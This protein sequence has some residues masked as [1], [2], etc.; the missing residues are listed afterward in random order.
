MIPPARQG[1]KQLLFVTYG[2]GHAH[3]I[4]PVAQALRQSEACARGELVVH[5]LGLPAATYTLKANGIECLGFGDFLDPVQDADAL[6]WGRELAAQH[7]SP[8]IG[9]TYEDSVAYLGLN[10]K[11]LVTRHGEAEAAQLMA[12]RG[13]HAFFPLT[14]MER[15]FDR[16]RPDFVV[17]SNSP[18]SEAAAISVANQRGIANLIMTDLFTGLGGY[19]LQGKGIT[20]LNRLAQ[21]M[22]QADGLVDPAVSEFHYTGN[23]AFDKILG[24]PRDKD[25][26]WMRK[27]FPLVGESKVV[28]HADMPAY[29]DGER[30]CSHF[31]TEEETLA[32]LQACHAAAQANGAAYLVRPHP[33]QERASYERWLAGRPG[34]WLAADCNLHELLANIDLLIARTTTVGLEAALMHKRILQLDSDFHRDLPL[35][36]MGVAWGANGY[37]ELPRRVGEVLHDDKGFEAIRQRIGQVLPTEPAAL[38]IADI[39][40]KKMQLPRQLRVGEPDEHP[41]EV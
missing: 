9:V 20:F 15:V 1:A 21:E 3:M 27:H 19:K 33:S 34:A 6:A 24:L 8:T 32:E 38:K 11:D 26:A 39:V 16:L 28:L 17:T 22:F 4:Y 36:A 29:W 25:P 35:A 10:Y 2:G 7:H 12:Q 41:R 23:P 14:V 40:L 31:K 5:V 13:R 18:R 30:Q 37:T